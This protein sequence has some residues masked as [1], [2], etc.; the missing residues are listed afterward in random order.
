[1]LNSLKIAVSCAP[2][3]F[4][5]MLRP[6]IENLTDRRHT[7]KICHKHT[8]YEYRHEKAIRTIVAAPDSSSRA[9]ISLHMG[10]PPERRLTDMKTT[11]LEEMLRRPTHTDGTI[12]SLAWSSSAVESAA[13]AAATASCRAAAAST[14]AISVAC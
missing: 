13:I 11:L 7:K 5:G 3:C 6:M 14:L 12:C 8:T 10:N 4:L 9:Q 1:M 2:S